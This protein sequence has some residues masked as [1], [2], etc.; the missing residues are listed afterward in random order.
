MNYNNSYLN[1]NSN[2][3][4]IPQNETIRNNNNESFNEKKL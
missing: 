4:S 3:N 1:F 2:I